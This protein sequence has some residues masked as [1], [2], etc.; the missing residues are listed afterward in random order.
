MAIQVQHRRGTLAENNAF[1]GAEGEFVYITDTEQVAVHDGV[2]QGGFVLPNEL[3]LVAD[4]FGYA[5]ATGTDTIALTVL[6]QVSAYQAGQ[7]FTFKAAATITGSAT[8]N[9]N[10]IG[11][12]TIKKKDTAAVSIAALVAN[13]IIVGGIYSVR[14]DGTDFQLI[15]TD[16]GGIADVSQ[17]DLNTATGSFS[18]AV[19]TLVTVAFSTHD[20]TLPSSTGAT[21]SLPG[22][23]YGFA[24]RSDAQLAGRH[25]GWWLCNDTTSL[26]MAAMPFRYFSSSASETVFGDQTYV[27][28]SPPFD[29]GDGEVGGFLFLELDNQGEVLGHYMADVPPWGYNGP[30]SIKADK[31]INGKK[32][33]KQ[34]RKRTIEQI[35]AD[36]TMAD[37]Y[38]MVEIT[39]DVK[40][41]DM[42][43]LPHPFGGSEN[44]IVMVDPMCPIV[45]KMIEMQNAGENMK[46][47][48]DYIVPDNESLNR[49]GPKGVQQVKYKTCAKK[50]KERKAKRGK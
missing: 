10:S 3:D 13:D 19:A 36:P 17:G 49:K 48:L 46:D 25:S 39:H 22:G 33:K 11:A 42:G 9:V 30:T 16:G 26:A 32:Y 24:P 29:M 15:S 45:K 38:D 23:Q 2:T 8:L 50:A 4:T 20:L 7:V 41:A 27:T 18:K 31:I 40:N 14:Y 1:T 5:T 37:Q 47:F 34:I 28:A 6:S 35:I 21:V 43:L 12:K 44:N